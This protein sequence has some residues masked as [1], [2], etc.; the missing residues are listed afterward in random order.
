MNHMG[1]SLSFFLVRRANRPIQATDHARTNSEEKETAR[2]LH[3]TK[4]F[5]NINKLL[6]HKIRGK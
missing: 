6:S 2:R 5:T 4:R 3:G 1:L